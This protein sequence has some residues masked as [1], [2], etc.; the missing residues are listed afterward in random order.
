MKT[1]PSCFIC[2][3]KYAPGLYKELR[4]LGDRLVTQG[5]EVYY[6]LADAYRGQ[7][8]AGSGEPHYL[9]SSADTRSMVTDSTIGLAS[10]LRRARSLLAQK[11]PRFVCVYNPHPLNA[12]LLRQSGRLVP[13][14]IRCIYLH[15]PAK[16]NKRAYG[17]FGA[18]YFGLVDILQAQAVRQTN[19]IVVASEHG[20]H[21]F[22]ER[23]P[24]YAGEVRVAPLLIPDRP[25]PATEKREY[26]TIAGRMNAGKGLD[27]FMSLVEYCASSR[28]HYRFQICTA[29]RMEQYLASLSPA[30]RALIR[31]IN[32]D[33]LSDDEISVA[34]ARSKAVFLLHKTATQSGMMTVAYMSGAPVIARDLPAFSQYIEHRVNSCLVPVAASPEDIL[35]EMR[36][37]EEHQLAL[38]AAARTTFER[39]F[40]EVNWARNYGWLLEK[41]GL[42]FA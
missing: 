23:F 34:V 36:Y 2:S 19:V 27:T 29:S 41:L 4:L 35:E 5:A 28:L 9:L 15:E 6:V 3:L 10:F 30:A 12:P 42:G 32:P 25:A 40:S 38:S 17:A 31:I 14:C 24:H 13:G 8:E 22:G 39:T 1:E 26:F 11:R 37:V 7:W 18:L 16:P 20:R 21:L 33:R